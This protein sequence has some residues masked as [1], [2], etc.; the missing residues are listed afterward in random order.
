[1]CRFLDA[2][3]HPY[4]PDITIQTM[5]LLKLPKSSIGHSMKPDFPIDT[6]KVMMYSEILDFHKVDPNTLSNQLESHDINM[7]P[8]Q[9]I[10]P[11]K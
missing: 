6:W 3:A 7:Q 10:D 9:T 4:L 5:N 2:L 8:Q 1:M 11:L